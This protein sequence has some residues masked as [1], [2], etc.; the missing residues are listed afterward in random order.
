MTKAGAP[1]CV[2]ESLTLIAMK[3]PLLLLL[4]AVVLPWRSAGEGLPAGEPPPVFSA[5]D[6]SLWSI[7]PL[8]EVMP[9][10]LESLRH[11]EWVRT[12]VDRFIAEKHDRYGLEPAPEA[13]ARDL[14]RR[15]YFDLIGLPPTLEEIRAFAATAP[16]PERDQAYEAIVDDLLQS[17]RYGERWAQHWFDLTR[18]AESDG[19]NLDEYRPAAWL[20]RDWVIKAF[21]TDMPYDR[22]VRE[23]LAG[24]EI[25]PDDPDVLIATSYLRNPIY[26][27]NQRDVRGQHQLILEDLTDNAGEVFLGL[28]IGCA[29]CHDHKFDPILQKD[30]YRLKAFF[31]PILWRTDLKLATQEQQAE[32]ARQQAIWEEATAAIREKMDA[33]TRPLLERNK[34]VAFERH[35]EDIEAMMRKPPHERTPLEHQ[36]ATLAYRQV[37]HEEKIFNPLTALKKPEDKQAWQAL[38]EQLQQFDHLKPKPLWEAFVATDVGPVA[39][40][41]PMKGKGVE[42]VAPGFL[43]ILDLG[44][45]P[46]TPLSHSTGR[47]TALAAWI[48]RP[49]NPLSTRAIVN[50]I[51]HYHFGRGIAGVPSDLGNMGEKPTHPELLDWLA[52]RF[53]KDGWSFKRLHKLLVTSSVY[54]QTAQRRPTAAINAVDPENRL[55]WRFP[56]RRLDAEQARDA[57]LAVSGELDLTLGG[58]VKDREKSTR[59]SV[60][61]PRLRNRPDEFLQQFNAPAG[62]VSVSERQSTTTPTQALY[63][64]N[65][66][67]VLARARA[68][69]SRVSGPEELWQ[70]V[71]G[72]E[73]QP[74]ELALAEDFLRERLVEEG[75]FAG[76][77]GGALREQLAT[78]EGTAAWQEALTDL[79]HVLLNNNEFFYLH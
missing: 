21:N 56:P 57:M 69:A 23:Q 70:R 36:L 59:R 68:V 12:E 77:E 3:W 55:W 47:R 42:D 1:S 10:A 34:R 65:G 18:F 2:R 9:P 37:Q 33:L 63:L 30:Y 17:P 41:N 58:E 19:Y 51:W 14:L 5:K 64:F 31:V 32:F 44:E 4:L 74:R 71:L 53:V 45:A 62:F 60:Y 13:D 54:R 67:W 43:S 72:R 40:P 79:A 25:A 15:V 75:R 52:S 29:R 66:D 38:N 26:E 78:P 6:R 7:Q 24:D 11:P 49:D 27:Y 16:G 28:S 48:T 50:R 8:A 35:R 76:A 73:L 20:Y 22:F 39:P 46:I 61:L